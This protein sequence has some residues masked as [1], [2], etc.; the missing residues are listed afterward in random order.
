MI[1][2]LDM[3]NLMICRDICKNY[4]SVLRISLLDAARYTQNILYTENRFVCH[5]ID[6]EVEFFCDK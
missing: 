3:Y 2:R 6:F 1:V 5:V 4:N